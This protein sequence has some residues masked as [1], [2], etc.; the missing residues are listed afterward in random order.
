[1]GV[2]AGADPVYLTRGIV[3]AHTAHQTNTAT[4]N[5]DDL[6]IYTLACVDGMTT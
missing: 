2:A 3:E 4:P 1:M 6:H 5:N